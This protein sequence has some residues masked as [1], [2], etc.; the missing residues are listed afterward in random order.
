MLSGPR[1]LLLLLIASTFL[2]CT[3]DK[4]Q[5]KDSAPPASS[6]LTGAGDV[7]VLAVDPAKVN[8][9]PPYL[10][11]GLD[12]E[13][14]IA[15]AVRDRYLAGTQLEA[16]RRTGPATVS[17]KFTGPDMPLGIDV[18]FI[19]RDEMI[20]PKVMNEVSERF[21]KMG[22]QEV[23]GLGRRALKNGEMQVVFWDDDT[24]CEVSVTGIENKVNLLDLSRDLVPAITPAALTLGPSGQE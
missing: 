11:P 19:C 17:C 1:T 18:S 13:R 20:D 3:S 5:Q 15:P 8:A 2:A 24:N 7:K 12:C 10:G 22:Y 21:K 16:R 14:L 6:A 4:E 23:A 9:P